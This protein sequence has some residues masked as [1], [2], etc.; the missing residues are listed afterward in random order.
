[1]KREASRDFALEADDGLE[2][3][4]AVGRHRVRG[5]IKR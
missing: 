3:E 5:V 2:R 1:M 4:R